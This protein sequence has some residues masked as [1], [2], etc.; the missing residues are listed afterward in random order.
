MYLPRH[1]EETDRG[2]LREL[3]ARNP[4][5]HIVQAVDGALQANPVPMLLVEDA[6][7]AWRLQ[8]HVARANPMWRAEVPV[9]AIIAGPDHYISPS[10]YPTKAEHG[11][12]V[13][14]WNYATWHAHGHLK[15]FES[16]DWL[17]DLLHRLT[18]T[19]ESRLPKPWAIDDAPADY[20]DGLLN[21]IVGIE[22]RIER[23]EAKFKLSQNHPAANRQGVLDG[24]AG[25]G[26]NDGAALRHQ[27]SSVVDPPV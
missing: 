9:L 22:I 12:V 14:T 6:D 23:I 2:R 24:L 8:G 7:G 18:T 20:I 10:W 17:I 21:A 25:G 15:A 13:P 16:R 27:M 19:H 11:R 26:E 1:F 5:V 4:L 3:V